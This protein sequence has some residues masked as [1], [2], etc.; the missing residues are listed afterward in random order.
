METTQQTKYLVIVAGPTAVGKTSVSIQ[1]AQQLNTSIISC[2]SRQFY[3]EMTIGTAKPSPEEL[4][5][6]PHHFINNLSI[7]EPYTVGDFEKEVLAF[8]AQQFQ[9]KQVVLM[10]GGSGL[11]IHAVCN[12]LDVFPDVDPAIRAA[13]K[14]QYLAQGIETLQTELQALDPV[15]FA[16]VDQANPQRIMRALEVCKST[17]KAYS[18]FRKK[19]AVKR[20]FQIIKIALNRDRNLLY[21]R[22]N[23]RVDIMLSE[24]LLAEAQALYPYKHINALQTVGYK[25]LF[26]FMDGEIDRHEAIRLIKR[27]SRRY[28]K[29]Q[30]T[31]LRKEP[32]WYWFYPEQFD[33]ISAFILAKTNT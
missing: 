26:S 6:A 19:Q 3:R 4:Q 11:Y 30:L 22:I 8:L 18:S 2:D 31:W 20:P 27:N 29:R 10:T 5:A 21:E 16:E 14:E 12:G 25:E 28:A 24:G 9:Q 7:K 32:D 23:K 13:I 1:L 15:Y 17:G 33:E